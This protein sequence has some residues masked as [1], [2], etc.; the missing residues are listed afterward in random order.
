[1][2]DD[3]GKAYR[4][5]KRLASQ[6]GDHADE[7]DFTLTAHL[8]EN[9]TPEQSI[10]RIAQHFANISQE[11]APLN[12]NLLPS[13]VQAKVDQ[14]LVDNEM[15]DLPDHDVYEKIR[16]SKKPKSSVPGDLPRKIVQEF[17]P[18]LSAPAGM[19]FRNIVKTGQWPKPWRIE[20][21]TP[22]KKVSNPD[23]ED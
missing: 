21:G 3:P 19:I 11:F 12:Y 6:P 1:M 22:L 17:G 7:G 18:E 9:L 13:D 5:L 16:K 2:K 8:N 15:P 14:P 20:Y 23:T 10:E 4:C